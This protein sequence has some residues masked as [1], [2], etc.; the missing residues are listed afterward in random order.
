MVAALLAFS[1]PGTCGGKGRQKCQLHAR[2]CVVGA[3]QTVSVLIVAV[4]GPTLYFYKVRSG[5]SERLI[6]LSKDTQLGRSKPEIPAP[7]FLPLPS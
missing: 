4:A 7:V 5:D 2:R 3:L 6:N 1:G